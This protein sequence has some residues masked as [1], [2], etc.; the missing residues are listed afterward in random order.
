[1]LVATKTD[2]KCSVENWT[3]YLSDKLNCTKLLGIPTYNW[4]NALIIR[5]LQYLADHLVLETLGKETYTKAENIILPNTA[6]V[7]T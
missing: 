2:L 6:T 1:M 7:T 3:G 4:Y 5:K